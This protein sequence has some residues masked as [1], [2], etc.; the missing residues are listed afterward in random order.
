MTESDYFK[1]NPIVEK[2]MDD[3]NLFTQTYYINNGMSQ[4]Y[5]AN[6]D[7]YIA[8]LTVGR[9]FL[10]IVVGNCVWGF[11]SRVNGSLK[12]YGIKK[13]DL[14]MAAGQSPAKHSRGNITDGTASFGVHGPNY[15]K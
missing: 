2:F 8:E 15:L 9:K 4:L 1:H 6:P 5:Y 7:Q 11:I 12:G 13:G 10:K 14:F 3:L